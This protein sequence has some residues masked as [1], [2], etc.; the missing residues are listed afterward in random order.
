LHER[1]G[2]TFLSHFKG[3]QQ[4]K[5][6]QLLH[7]QSNFFL[8]IIDNNVSVLI[9]DPGQSLGDSAPKINELQVLVRP[10]HETVVNYRNFFGN[11]RLLSVGEFVLVANH[12][13]VVQLED[14]LVSGKAAEQ[15]L[16]H[17]H[18][19]PLERVAATL[20][21]EF[22]DNVRGNHARHLHE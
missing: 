17:A 22:V 13:G 7:L 1:R 6:G 4:V 11:G 10:G 18:L 16:L 3:D 15:Q 8:F 20:S 19:H 12:H 5:D 14:E 21:Q 9:F 2:A